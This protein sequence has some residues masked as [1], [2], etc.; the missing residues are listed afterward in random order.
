MSD[1]ISKEDLYAV[2]L[3]GV[4]GATSELSGN[5]AACV[6]IT[7]IT[8]NGIQVGVAVRDSKLPADDPRELRFNMQ[9]W[10]AF[11][12]GMVAGQANLYPPT[13]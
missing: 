11:G 13:A 2:D 9:E 10:N 8:L 3:T 6:R 7:P 5:G 12:G 1:Q 4:E